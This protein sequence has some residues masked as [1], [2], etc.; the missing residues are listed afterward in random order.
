VDL[1]AWV[2]Q[3]PSDAVHGFPP[4]SD[5]TLDLR[6]LRV[7]DASATA[8]AVLDNAEIVDVALERC[9]IAGVVVF[10]G[11]VERLHVSGSR[12]RGVTWGA[13]MVQDVVLE[14]TTGG[15]VSLRSSTLRR[16]TF[17]DCVLPGLD[18]TEVT[19]DQVRLE[20]CT[21]TGATF[22]RAKVKQL[23]IEGCDLTGCSG[24]EALSGASVH[25]DDLLYLAPSLAAA[26]GITLEV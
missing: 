5:E 7:A 8:T 13:G 10:N 16:V 26:L 21:L 15:D 24:A 11:R 23:R 18:L 17:R 25:P 22:H 3:L 14:S 6:D 1:P 19:F 9:D 2:A 12:L 4:L 20:H